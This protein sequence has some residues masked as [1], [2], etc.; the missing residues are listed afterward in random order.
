MDARAPASRPGRDC[1]RTSRR[2]HP[3]F[4]HLHAFAGNILTDGVRVTAVID[5]GASCLAG[6]RRL[7]PI[8]SA[9]YLSDRHVT[10][11]ATARDVDA[12]LAWL[13]MNGLAEWLEP[14][15]RWLAAY[16][17]FEA[18]D[19][20]PSPGAVMFYS[21]RSQLSERRTQ[22]SPVAESTGPIQL[23]IR[24]THT[25]GDRRPDGSAASNGTTDPPGRTVP[26]RISGARWAFRLPGGALSRLKCLS[27]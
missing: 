9:V 11:T 10:P 13:R 26:A 15:R 20:R 27:A 6:D 21:A 24:G 22:G 8:A 12:A 17:S 16:W 4:V 23:T 1:P 5:F 25:R 7:D 19:R 14:G 3:S 2:G 18:D